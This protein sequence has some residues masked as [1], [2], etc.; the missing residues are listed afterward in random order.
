MHLLC[1]IG[2]LLCIN[3]CEQLYNNATIILPTALMY[4]LN[5]MGG[6]Q[7]VLSVFTAH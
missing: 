6:L 3:H 2:Q 7:N 4:F 1:K 5:S